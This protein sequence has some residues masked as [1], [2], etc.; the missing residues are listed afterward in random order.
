[1]LIDEIKSE[2]WHVFMLIIVISCGMFLC[3]IANREAVWEEKCASWTYNKTP[4]EG[5]GFIDSIVDKTKF[6]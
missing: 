2:C 4:S 1:M 6:K 5:S 3:D